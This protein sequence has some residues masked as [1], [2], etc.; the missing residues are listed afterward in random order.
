MHRLAVSVAFCVCAIALSPAASAGKVEVVFVA[1]EGYTDIGGR[2]GSGD[3]P[4]KEVVLREIHDHLVGLGERNL[5][6][7]QEL[8]IEILDIDIA[9][10][11]DV[12][13]RGGGE[14]ARVYQRTTWPRIELR[15]SLMQDGRL[16]TSGQDRLTDL[17]YLDG[18]IRIS[19]GDPIR[20]ERP[21]L[22]KW[23]NARFVRR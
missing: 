6:P 22:S 3:V 16:V 23:F 2:S 18:R 15:Y 14:D 12:L 21:M 13:G 19:A 11:R 9:G 10:R 20:Y 8:T 4:T 5:S 7:A 17:T 1:P